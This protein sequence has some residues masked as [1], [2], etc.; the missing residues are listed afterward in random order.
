MRD[1]G[2]GADARETRADHGHV[3]VELQLLLALVLLAVV[4][5]VTRYRTHGFWRAALE[6]LLASA[7]AG[8]GFVGLVA[9]VTELATAHERLKPFRAYR[10]LTVVVSQLAFCVMFTAFAALF[11]AIAEVRFG[12]AERWGRWLV[13]AASFATG[14]VLVVVRRRQ[15]ETFWPAAKL[16][17]GALCFG[18]YGVFMVLCFGGLFVV[19]RTWPLA[20]ADVGAIAGVVVFG[21]GVAVRRWT[22]GAGARV[23]F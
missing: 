12:L 20:A 14:V 16:V 10:V 1:E 9:A 13:P 7:I 15:R 8:G 3:F 23:R 4:V 6:G 19:P 5:A 2:R 17:C 21:L 22:G 11:W 18:L